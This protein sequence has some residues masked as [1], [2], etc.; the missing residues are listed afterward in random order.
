MAKI[1]LDAQSRA[2]L[3]GE[4]V[5]LAD[6]VVHYE[7]GGP[8]DGQKVVLV[9][10]FTTPYFMWDNNFDEL[11]GAGFRV[12]QYDLY[13]R[14]YSDRPHL[15]YGL[16]LYDR[17][18]LNLLD[19]LNFNEPVDLVGLSMGGPITGTFTDRHP[20]RVRKLT[21]LAPAGEEG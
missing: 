11:T 13:G 1:K 14:G 7:V 15:V 20:R 2:N 21:L 10:G 9:H 12:L 19:A 4:F 17:Q 6:G 16:D 5:E 8:V 3:P 18:L